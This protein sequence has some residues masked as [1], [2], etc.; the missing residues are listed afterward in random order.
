MNAN[1]E[2]A[3]TYA[4]NN[5]LILG[6]AS[7]PK[8]L[9]IGSEYLKEYVVGEQLKMAHETYQKSL[10]SE[11]RSCDVA[12]YVIMD[13]D[14]DDHVVYSSV[15]TLPSYSISDTLALNSRVCKELARAESRGGTILNYGW[16]ISFGGICLV[17]SEDSILEQM[18]SLGAFSANEIERQYIRNGLITHMEAQRD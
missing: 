18:E 2:N 13:S 15:N 16:A 1:L 9:T 8:V 12:I 6:S 4:F 17:S 11:S 5:T 14:T 10:T 3:L 7:M